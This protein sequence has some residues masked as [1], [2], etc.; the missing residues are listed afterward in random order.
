MRS[1]VIQNRGLYE[2]AFRQLVAV[3]QF[4][5]LF[6]KDNSLANLQTSSDNVAMGKQMLAAPG[7][8]LQ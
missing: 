3:N 8:G 5:P 4:S 6:Q 7:Q 2:S 1:S